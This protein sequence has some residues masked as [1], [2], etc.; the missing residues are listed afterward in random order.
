MYGH[1]H[2]DS[3]PREMPRKRPQIRMALLCISIQKITRTFAP[4]LDSIVLSK[5]EFYVTRGGKPC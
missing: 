5:I 2:L 1:G 4:S 3:T